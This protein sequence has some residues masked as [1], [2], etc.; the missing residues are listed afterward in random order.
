VRSYS[1]IEVCCNEIQACAAVFGH[2]AVYLI[3]LDTIREIRT[4]GSKRYEMTDHLGN[5]LATIMDRKSGYVFPANPGAIDYTG[6][7]ANLASVSDYYPFGFGMKERTKEFSWY[8]DGFNGKE[9]DDEVYGKNNFQDYGMR[10]YDTRI[11]RFISVDPLTSSFPWNSTYAFAEGNPIE[12][13]DLDGLEKITYL[14]NFSGEKITRTKIVHPKAGPLRDGVLVKSN[15]GNAL[16]YFYGKEVA[17]KSLP[18]YK[19]SY[20]GTVKDKQGNHIWYTDNKGYPTIGYGHLVKK[21]DPYRSGSK[22]NEK[23]ATDLFNSDQK[24]IFSLADKKLTK[25]KLTISQRHALYD[26]AFNGGPGKLD[27]Y[28]EDGGRY[29]GENYFLKPGYLNDSP[30]NIKRR[31]GDNLL[32]T[33]GLYIHLDQIKAKDV[34]TINKIETFL[35]PPKPKEKK[36]AKE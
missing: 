21:G 17:E 2:L 34:K 31:Y 11:A 22:L 32:Y 6:F 15:F 8:R 4:L 27:N 5:V 10:M 29:S 18:A 7:N 36:D 28:N 19:A 3:S 30:G 13:I 9:K 12:N 16:K 14:F 23:E 20:E 35:N 25:F 1:I 26:L 33:E 24:E